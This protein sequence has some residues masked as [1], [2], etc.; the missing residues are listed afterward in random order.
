[1]VKTTAM[2]DFIEIALHEGLTKE[3]DGTSFNE[4][5]RRKTKPQV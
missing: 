4:K 3:L 1:M 2:R 5:E